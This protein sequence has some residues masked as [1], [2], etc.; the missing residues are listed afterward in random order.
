MSHIKILLVE[1][2]KFLRELMLSELSR[3]KD[4]EIVGSAASAEEAVQL[5]NE[6]SPDVVVM[7]I[8]LPGK[9]GIEACR[10]IRDQAPNAK[11]VILTSSTSQDDLFKALEAGATG[12]VSKNSPHTRL[13]E[14][15]RLAYEGHALI[16][17]KVTLPLIQ[18]FV[19][20]RRSQAAD[21]PLVDESK[22][23]G[24]TTREIEILYLV[25]QGKSNMEIARNVNVQEVTV[26]SH[27]HQLLRKLSMTNRMQLAIFAN[28]LGLRERP[29]PKVGDPRSKDQSRGR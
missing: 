4:L 22:I 17:P 13:L 7:D 27:V 1:D 21:L 18:E 3:H 12:F 6:Q 10:E 28:D 11:I 29:Q 26:K 9:S 5:I 14:A 24:L 2:S 15:V 23:Q 8:N 25:G 16:D 20:F 19:Q